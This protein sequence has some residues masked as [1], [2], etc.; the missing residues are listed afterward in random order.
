MLVF[1]SAFAVA[2]K[3]TNVFLLIPSLLLPLFVKKLKFDQKIIR[4]QINLLVAW[5]SFKFGVYPAIN[6][7]VYMKNFA[8]AL[9]NHPGPYGTG[10]YA[11]FDAPAYLSS[12]SALIRESPIM[13]GFICLNLLLMLYILIKRKLEIHNPVLFLNL[14]TILGIV[15][16]AKYPFV[17]YNY[18]NIV[19]LIFCTCYLLTKMKQIVVE[20]LIFLLIAS[21]IVSIGKYFRN[22]DN[23]ID[24]FNKDNA[25]ASLES[26]T[27]YWSNDL[28]REQFN[29]RLT[30]P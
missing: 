6:K 3:L 27:L 8:T 7:L 10:H 25:Y 29:T 16:F 12:V 4:F 14:F 1:I 24:E 17:H 15:V 22:I 30:K 28:F 2:N 13:F 18:I 21:S 20:V 11:I 5:F 23:R 9:L 19:I 26:W